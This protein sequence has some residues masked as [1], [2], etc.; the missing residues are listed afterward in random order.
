MTTAA[1]DEQR[2]PAR[3]RLWRVTDR[4]TFRELRRRGRRARRG[5][6]AVTWLAPEPSAPPTPPRVAFATGKAVGGS[7]R[8]NRV[9]RRIRAALWE[10]QAQGRLPR[11]SYLLAGGVEVARMPWPDVVAAVGEAVDAATVDAA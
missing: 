9:R 8:R 7:V 1:R 11:G 2:A 5:A 3:P 10:L 6:V 4:A